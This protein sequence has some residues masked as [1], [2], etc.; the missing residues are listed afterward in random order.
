MEYRF[1]IKR[2]ESLPNEISIS[3]EGDSINK[4]DACRILVSKNS[5]VIYNFGCKIKLQDEIR[6]GLTA[7][8]LNVVF[9]IIAL[10]EKVYNSPDEVVDEIVKTIDE[11][12][13]F[14]LY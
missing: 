9:A 1:I 11:V 14:L 4:D 3:F 6:P 12:S 2:I 10:Q 7:A 5:E 8:I 13:R